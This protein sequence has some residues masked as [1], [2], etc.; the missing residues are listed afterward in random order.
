MIPGKRSTCLS[1]SPLLQSP[2]ITHKHQHCH[3]MAAW[4]SLLS[5]VMYNN[6]GK[7]TQLYFCFYITTYQCH[8]ELPCFKSF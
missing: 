5:S 4:R 1:E 6:D 3:I 7:K 2:N 8:V